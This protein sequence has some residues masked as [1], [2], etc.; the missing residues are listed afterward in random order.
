LAAWVLLFFSGCFYTLGRCCISK[1]K[2]RGGWDKKNGS[3]PGLYDGGS[4]E[5]LRLD[6]VKAEAER[7]KRQKVAEVGLPAFHEVQ[8]L[9]A[10]VD[11]DN[12]YLEPTYQ[13][14]SHGAYGG[15]PTQGGGFSGGGY[16]PSP[17]G[18]RAV[19]DYYAPART[20]YP[21]SAY[22]PAPQQTGFQG[23]GYA[24]E[25][26][27]RHPQRQDSGYAQSQYTPSLH[28]VS[29]GNQYLSTAPQQY[30]P[31]RYGSPPQG[32][33]HTTGG[34]SYY[35]AVSHTQQPTNYSQFDP[36]DS[37][38]QRTQT[39]YNVDQNN[40]AFASPHV[41]TPGQHD[42]T[43][44]L[45]G[46]G[47]GGDGYGTNTLPPLPEHSNSFF[48]SPSQVQASPP[49]ITTNIGHASPPP[50]SPLRGPRLQPQ[51]SVRNDMDDSPPVYEAGSSN[52]QG[53][54]GKS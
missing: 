28:T 45:G 49:P 21:T 13:D 27:Q 42:R 12:V 44:T 16:A 52:I 24:A 54:W 37:Q 43:Y 25:Y 1:R 29:T 8:P 20:D 17:V 18:S 11:G 53:A 40:S 7:K 39:P 15:R 48:A 32:Y 33:G 3:E 6:A 22:P 26:A 46:G 19:D 4:S 35:S 5:Q 2:Q 51:L 34:S 41:P 50:T 47:Y 14:N 10:R 30:G 38:Q 9:A 36:Y 23:G 31:E